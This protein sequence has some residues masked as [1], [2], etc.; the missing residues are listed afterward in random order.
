VAVICR[1][2][3]HDTSG[4]AFVAYLREHIAGYKT[5]RHVVFIDVLPKNASGK[6]LKRELRDLIASGAIVLEAL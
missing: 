3:G 4:A 5:P 6:V 2:E 1:R